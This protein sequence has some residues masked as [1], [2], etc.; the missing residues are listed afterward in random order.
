VNRLAFMVAAGIA[1]VMALAGV[2]ADDP[3][4]GTLRG[5]LEGGVFLGGYAVVLR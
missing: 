3:Y 4:D 5:L 1:I 2:A